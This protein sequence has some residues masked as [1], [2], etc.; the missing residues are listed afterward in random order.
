VWAALGFLSVGVLV[1]AGGY[2]ATQGA[3]DWT[4][5]VRDVYSNF[6]S[7]LI[8]IALT[9]IVIETLNN[10]RAERERKEELI[11]QM[12]SPNNGFAVEAVRVLT[13]KGWLQD[14]SLWRANLR[15]ANLQSAHLAGAVMVGADLRFALLQNIF[16]GYAVLRTVSLSH[17]NLTNADLRCVD[18]RA[19][20]LN[21][22]I[23]HG[24]S[25]VDADLEGAFIE[26]AHFDPM[27]TL[28]DQTKWTPHT[29]LARFT[30]P[31]H[32]EFFRSDY[33]GSPAF[34]G[35]ADV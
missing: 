13:Q 19:A 15:D 6:G 1:V 16:A 22:T 35:H 25:L 23:L 30:N 10:R 26:R 33:K 12:G 4:T 7:E 28:P 32:P 8:S 21:E 31:T 11:L 18:L 34:R 14:G 3:F 27:T 29:D 20:V 2:S 17:A 5:F 9:V 24:A